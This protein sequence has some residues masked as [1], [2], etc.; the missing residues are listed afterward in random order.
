VE[1]ELIKSGKFRNPREELGR[2]KFLDL[3]REYAENSK[4]RIIE[5]IKSL[6]TSCDWSRLAYTFDESRSQAVN[7]MFSR[8]YHDG[9]IYRGDRIVNWDWKLQTTVSDDELEWQEEKVPFYYFKYGPFEIST[10]RPETKFGDKYV[11]MHPDDKRYKKYQHGEELEVEWINGPVKATVIKDKAI[12]PEFGTGVMTITPWHDQTDFDIAERHKLDKQQIIGFDGR[13]LDIAG[14]FKGMKIAEAREKIVAKM[15]AKSL[16][17][18]VDENYIHRVARSD[19]G[20]VVVEPQI[21]RQWF[22]AVNKKIPGKSKTL[23]D[24]MREAVTIGHNKD[25]KQLIKITP[26]RFEKQYLSWIDNL[27][28]WCISRQIWWGH[29]IPVW[30]RQGK[31]KRGKVKSNN[32]EGSDTEIYVG[33]EAPKGDAWERDSDTL[34]TWFSSGMWT[35]ST[36]GWPKNTKDLKT[37][38][39]TSWMQMGYE[40]LFFWMARMILMSC[41]GL[42]QIPFRQVYFHGMLRNKQGEKFSKSLGNG[43]DPL[44]IAGQYGTDSLRLSLLAGVSPG[45]DAKFYLEKVTGYRNFVNKLWNISRFILMT[46]TDRKIIQKQPKLNS[47]ADQWIWS[48]YTATVKE[49]TDFMDSKSYSLAAEKLYEFTWSKLADWYL[50]VAKIENEL[51]PQTKKNRDSLLLYILQKLL[52]LWH[53][54]TPFATELIWQQFEVKQPLIIASWPKDKLDQNA[55]AA[56]EFNQLQTIV[57]SIRNLRSEKKI[58]AK[59]ILNASIEWSKLES[60]QPIIEKLARVKIVDQV[61]GAELKGDGWSGVVEIGIGS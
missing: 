24:L 38:H 2:E 19:R 25:K 50:E 1:K 60:W 54:F 42:D 31:S 56:Q 17:V 51:Q 4:H 52:V 37:Y 34:D 55:K 46:T 61:Q 3:V 13:L 35:F 21:S 12:D 48:E 39:P 7:E 59:L 8:M 40:L 32:G 23:K 11:V 6:G 9:L 28:D 36:L 45:N 10:A 57:S 33:T 29:R 27:H 58:E 43:I 53:P 14:E 47:V 44:D 41:Y 16:L 30:Y 5:Q 20:G 26:E 18:K 22:V 49:I 15:Q